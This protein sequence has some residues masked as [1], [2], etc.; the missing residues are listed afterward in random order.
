MSKARRN[1]IKNKKNKKMLI[2]LVS[3]MLVI[4]VIAGAVFAFGTHKC[5]DCSKRFFGSGYYKEDAAQGV[6][7]S[8]L[9]SLFGDTEGI[10]V[11]TVEGVI[12]CQECA[13]NNPSVK[14]ELRTVKEFRR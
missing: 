7:S 5:D 2:S 4:V 6:I 3:A 9:G 14:T 12:I 8:A 13:K 11:K 10:S 1:A